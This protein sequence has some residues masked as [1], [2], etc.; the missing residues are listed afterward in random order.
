MRDKEPSKLRAHDIAERVNSGKWTTLD[1]AEVFAKKTENLHRLLNTHIYWDMDLA[2][3]QAEIQHDYN[4]AA[5]K[6]GKRLPLAGVPFVIKDNIVIKNSITTCGSKYLESF[7]SP[8]SAT[9]VERLM[10]AGAL[11]LGKSNLDEFGMG[12]TN[13]FSHFG[14]VAN[15]WNTAH[16][17][18][19]SSGGSAAAVSAS[20]A[21]C[22][23][24]SDTGGSVR[25]PASFCGIVG[26][27]PSYGRVSRYGL[28]AYASSLDQI[29]PMAKSCLDAA[30]VY[31]VISGFDP[32]DATSVKKD[33]MSA[34]SAIKSLQAESLKGW[35]IGVIEELLDAD[36]QPEVSKAIKQSIQTLT[37]LGAQIKKISI[38]SIKFAVSS[39]YLI[40][41][42]E[43]SSNL[44]RFDGVRYGYSSQS[45]GA[46]LRDLY[47]SSRSEG[48]GPEVKKRI[49]LGAF[50]LSSGYYD[51]YYNKA[52]HVRSLITK[53]IDRSFED[54]DIMLLPTA[55]TTAF[56]KGS[57]TNDSL[58]M[59]TSD[60]F[61]I[62]ANLGGFPAISLPCGYDD[63]RL[64]IGLQLMAP[65]FA[66]TALFQC[67]YQYE[68]AT[69]W[70]EKHEP[71]C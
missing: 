42:A 60:L 68:Q 67:A 69:K 55:A 5:L 12:S 15:P 45:S 63:N 57:K 29:G 21:T 2:L 25:Q 59:Y 34:V 56:P 7:R 49:M 23:L 35:R 47:T 51:A 43:A 46:S 54:V 66:E 6:S 30:L 64:P 4:L 53:E 38:P 11:V 48:F 71:R 26:L 27:K 16:V 17:P 13:E 14:P 41:T 1:I 70:V 9:A 24:G 20:M 44:S 10:A 62:L 19:G 40:A 37:D 36:L 28:V 39:Y 18:G 52:L 65:R 33:V 61:T 58:A 3:R 50:S 22:A 31:D 32:L 8:Y